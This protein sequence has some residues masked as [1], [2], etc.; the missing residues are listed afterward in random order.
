MLG[1]CSNTCTGSEKQH[2]DRDD[3]GMTGIMSDTER[4]LT[5]EAIFSV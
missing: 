5:P 3:D 2:G 4:E 1:S